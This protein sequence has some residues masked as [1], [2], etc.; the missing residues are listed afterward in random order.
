MKLPDWLD[1]ITTDPKMAVVFP[2]IIVLVLVIITEIL[3][4]QPS[5]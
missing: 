2:L 5:I 3:K 1:M 4:W